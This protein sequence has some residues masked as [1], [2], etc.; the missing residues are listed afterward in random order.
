MPGAFYYSGEERV[1]IN[2]SGSKNREFEIEA[3]SVSKY[4]RFKQL[5]AAARI[6]NVESSNRNCQDWSLNVLEWLRQEGFTEE[7]YQ[8]NVIRYWLREEGK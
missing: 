4:N 3:I 1:K 5:L 2:S 7:E 6:E 8:N